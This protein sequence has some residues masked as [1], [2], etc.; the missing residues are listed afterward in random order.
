MKRKIFILLL[1]FTTM[2]MN[3]IM[4]YA[5]YNNSFEEHFA[6]QARD[7][8]PCRKLTGNVRIMLIFVNTPEHP[9]TE[10]KKEEVYSVSTSSINIMKKEAARYGQYLNL[11]YGHLDFHIPTEYDDNQEWYRYILEKAY[12]VSNMDVIQQRYRR[13]LRVDSA[14]MIFLFN[15]WDRSYSKVKSSLNANYDDEYCVIFCDTD[16][17]DNYLT[18]ELMHLYGAIDLYD[19]RGEGVEKI[20]KKYFPTSDMLHVSHNIDDLTAFLV[21]WTETISSNASKFLTETDGLR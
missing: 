7:I 11:S 16:M 9:W 21:G 18:H 19:Y 12:H 14:P 17:H 2:I 6:L 4:A 13:A 5:D 15:S 20:A 8:G 10:K 3:S 1:V